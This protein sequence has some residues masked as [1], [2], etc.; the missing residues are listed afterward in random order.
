MS[1]NPSPVVPALRRG[2]AAVL[3]LAAAARPQEFEPNAL[4]VIDLAT[5]A[6]RLLDSG[7]GLLDEVDVEFA[8]G[9]VFGAA[10]GPDGRLY[11]ASFTAGVVYVLDRNGGFVDTIGAGTLT[12]PTDVA[13]GPD[14]ELY[15]TDF[16]DDRVVVFDAQGNQQDDL[17]AGTPMDEPTSVAVFPGGVLAVANG[18]TDTV[19]R[20]QLGGAYIDELGAA[21]GIQ[22]IMGVDWPR[23]APIWVADYEGDRVLALDGAG[24]VLVTLGD[25][26]EL[27]GPT[28]VLQG[29]DRHVWVASR[30]TGEVLVYAWDNSIVRRL[31]SAALGGAWP[32]ALA[33]A[34]HRFHV[35]LKG[36]LGI[37]NEGASLHQELD[38][39]LA[40]Q[41]GRGTAWLRLQDDPEDAAD[42]AS[43]F[44]GTLLH[45]AGGEH[46]LAGGKQRH[47]LGAF[48]GG[49]DFGGQVPSLGL[50]WKAGQDAA[51]VPVLRSAKGTLHIGED[52]TSCVAT[53]RTA[54][55]LK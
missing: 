50:R 33:V 37:E 49:S 7:G 34:P 14:G 9:N 15:V 47:W 5:P 54:G 6:L 27:D 23:D 26:G 35:K 41:P 45:F 22:E 29:P 31:D 18:G 52:S 21:A 4:A 20:F 51:G 36:P 11:V 32:N 55:L 42:L 24:E 10:F 8:L 3:L 19:L 53:V 43:L 16:A 44:G 2:A 39:M 30:L 1:R 46:A 40:F 28:D 17:G 38:A 12:S 25:D 48:D 13:I